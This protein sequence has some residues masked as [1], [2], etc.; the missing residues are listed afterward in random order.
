MMIGRHTT[1]ARV[2]LG[3]FLAG[4]QNTNSGRCECVAGHT[5]GQ[6][7][8]KRAACVR[9]VFSHRQAANEFEC[10][11]AAEP[12]ADEESTVGIDLVVRWGDWEARV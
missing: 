2:T 10:C 5:E 4:S 8:M 7:E 3:H 9:G 1:G 12:D 6:V 11:P